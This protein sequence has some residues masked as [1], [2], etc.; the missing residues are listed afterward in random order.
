MLRGRKELGGENACM[1]RI[2]RG[3]A[4]G[5]FRACAAIEN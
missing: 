1:E 4:E 5:R 3:W 2:G